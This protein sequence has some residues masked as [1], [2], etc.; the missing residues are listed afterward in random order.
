MNPLDGE[1]VAVL[2]IRNITDRSLRH[3]QDEFIAAAGHELRTP[4][5]VLSGY[6]AM[7]NRRGIQDERLQRYIDLG[8]EQATRIE[9]LIG[10]LLDV[11]RLQSN[12]ISLDLEDLDLVQIVESQI[13]ACRSM[14]ETQTIR[15]RGTRASLH[16]RGDRLRIEQ[17]LG[18][19][20]SNALE[21]ASESE[22]VDVSIRRKQGFA[23]VQVQDYGPGIPASAQERIF[24]RFGQAA[25]DRFKPRG[26]GL[27]LF[28]SRQ[29][30]E[31]HGGT[32]RV[33]SKEGEGSTFSFRLPLLPE[34]RQK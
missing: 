13:E 31:A 27:G 32:L 29:L 34:A 17:V 25:S 11:G 1:A 14:T 24:D 28:I 26:L 15:F 23:E 3:F 33:E 21:H 5:T 8:R 9:I 10:Q 6:L 19:L 22:F 12:N 2:V 7:M 20:L 4:L 16:I 18:N 30:A